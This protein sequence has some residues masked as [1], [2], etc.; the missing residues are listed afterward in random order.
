LETKKIQ[1]FN[2]VDLKACKQLGVKVYR[3]PAYSPYAV[4]E[5]AVGLILCLNRKIHKAYNRVREM[6]FSLEGLVGFD[7]NGKT[8]TPFSV[9]WLFFFCFFF[10]FL[11][12]HF[13]S[14]LPVGIIGTGKIGQVLAKI[15]H[16]FGCNL[17][18]YDVFQTPELTKLYNLKYVS[19][20]E[21]YAQSG[22]QLSNEFLN[23]LLS[24]TDSGVC[25]LSPQR[26][27]FHPRAVVEGNG[28]FDQQRFVEENEG[29]SDD[30]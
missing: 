13:F 27:Y 19:L 15:M 26:H 7:M 23:L 8:G 4:A 18:G 29:R 22:T 3:V 10:F 16:G 14:S 12:S 24:S 6:N 17:V 30:Y 25:F 11:F 2:N 1:G 21:L 9:F 28:T 5:H 20:D